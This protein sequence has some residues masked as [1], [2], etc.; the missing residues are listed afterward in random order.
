[1]T[2]STPLRLAS[3]AGRFPRFLCVQHA[4][5][6]STNSIAPFV[7]KAPNVPADAAF[8]DASW[9]MP[10]SPRKAHQEFLK[11]RLPNARFLDLDEVASPSDLGLKHM[12]PEA[13][14]FADYCG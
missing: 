5:Q 9:H 11:K 6:L 4:R 2:L 7:V 14:V 1:M 3:T 10:N 13:R 8:I 12:M